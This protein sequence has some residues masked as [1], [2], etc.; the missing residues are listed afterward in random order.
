MIYVTAS[1]WKPCVA[2]GPLISQA[3]IDW[4]QG[5]LLPAGNLPF[6]GPVHHWHPAVDRW[7]NSV[8]DA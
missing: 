7:A 8:T 5:L 4:H 1:K 6:E 3:V 2:A